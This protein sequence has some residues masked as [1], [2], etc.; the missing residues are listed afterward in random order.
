ME[1]VLRHMVASRAGLQG[2]QKC[3]LQS[4]S[5]SATGPAT[6]TL[7]VASLEVRYL[8]SQ[9][10]NH[11]VRSLYHLSIKCMW[12]LQNDSAVDHKWSQIT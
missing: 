5:S 11:L 1:S 2:L 10:A 3:A 9:E 7:E 12:F 8:S 6:L 4:S